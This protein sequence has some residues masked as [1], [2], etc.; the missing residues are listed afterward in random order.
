MA[1]Q[2]DVVQ[3]AILGAIA[4]IAWQFLRRFSTVTSTLTAP[5]AQAWFN[6]TAPAAAQNLSRVKL[7][8]GTVVPVQS[9]VAAGGTIDGRGFFKWQGVQYQVTGRAPDGAYTALRVIT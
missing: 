2:T 8:T 4:F 1:K 7:P 6:L 9:I 5:V 3:L